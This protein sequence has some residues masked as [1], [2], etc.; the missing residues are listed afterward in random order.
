MVTHLREIGRERRRRQ[1]AG[2]YTLV[3]LL[4]A[5]AVGLLLMSSALFVVRQ[6]TQ[7]RGALL[8]GSAVQEEVQYSIAWITSVLRSAGANPYG[9]TTSACPSS[10]TTFAPIQL[11]PNGT[12]TANNVRIQADIN[13]P[14]GLL[15]GNS[16][17]CTESGEDITIAHDVANQAI[18]KLDNN[19]DNAASAM[20]D[21]VISALLFTYLDANR[22]ATTVPAQVVYVQVSVTGQ[23][24]SRDVQQ[25][26]PTTYTLTS[27][28]RIRLR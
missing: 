15:G 14:N 1:S 3:E 12:G 11:D 6:T 16:G 18:T 2:G 21:R 5:M 26:A 22:V 24:V 23:T 4:M 10:E 19:T 20:T 9:I 17:A 28:V 7:A 25:G 13:P 27:E 8:D